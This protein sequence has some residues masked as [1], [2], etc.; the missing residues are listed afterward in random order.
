MRRRIWL[1]TIQ[2]ASLSL[3]G[4]NAVAGGMRVGQDEGFD[5]KVELDQGSTTVWV[6][7]GALGTVRSEPDD[8]GSDRPKWIGCYVDSVPGHSMVIC[9]ALSETGDQLMC[10]SDNSFLVN[11]VA[12]MN[13]DSYITFKAIKLP[14][15]STQP[16][17]PC[18]HISVENN[19][20]YN[21]KSP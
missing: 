11:T 10:V 20:K 18:L 16:S 13:A 17:P 6:A 19:S 2:L 14:P 7:S 3:C 1:F 8:N 9:D 5:C 15:N 12:T 4:G 21:V